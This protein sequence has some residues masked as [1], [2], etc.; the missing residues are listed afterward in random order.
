MRPLALIGLV[1]L[2]A[3]NE[4]E[5]QSQRK[6]SIAVAAG[7]FDDLAEP[8][9]RNDVRHYVYDGI[10]AR[11]TWDPDYVPDGSKAS[12][13]ALLTDP[14]ELSRHDAVWISSGTRGLG[15]RVYN[16]EAP[17]NELVKSQVVRDNVEDFVRV[18]GV[19]LAT[20]WAYDLIEA[21]WPEALELS[22]DDTELDDAQVGDD[23]TV[24]AE[25][26]EDQLSDVIGEGF[27]ALDFNY[28]NAAVVESVGPDVRVWLQG[29][30]TLFRAGSGP[31]SVTGAPMLVDF[32]PAGA[33][34]RVIFSTFHLNAQRAA[35]TDAVIEVVVG[36]SNEGA[37]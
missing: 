17:D 27:V 37:E 5:F 25:V 8:L 16:G 19:V 26:L 32:Q 30:Q 13:E 24:T 11:A 10:I 2:G 9:D 3:C 34:G 4:Q 23:V 7:D 33:N 36:Q 15:K 20:D 29:D 18:G 14:S 21:I 1:L 28:S 31:E 22:G 12:V 6:N 35:F